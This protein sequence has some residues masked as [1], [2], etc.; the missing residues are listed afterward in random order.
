[1]PHRLESESFSNLTPVAH[2]GQQQRS[3]SRTRNRMVVE[4]TEIRQD[5]DKC[6]NDGDNSR[7]GGYM[8]VEISM[9]VETIL[10]DST[11]SHYGRPIKVHCE[12]KIIDE[13]VQQRELRERYR[14]QR[15]ER[16]RE[17]MN[18]QWIS[19]GSSDRMGYQINENYRNIVENDGKR[20]HIR[21]KSGSLRE[22]LSDYENIINNRNQLSQAN[23]ERAGESGY[24]SE[25]TTY[26]ETISTTRYSD[27][28][29]T[30]EYSLPIRNTL[31]N[32]S[33]SIA[34]HLPADSTITTETTITTTTA[35][36]KVAS[37]SKFTEEN[38]APR[39]SVSPVPS[40]SSPI[41]PTS[42]TSTKLGVVS[43]LTKQFEMNTSKQQTIDESLSRP[44]NGNKWSPKG[45]PKPKE[46]PQLL[47]SVEFMTTPSGGKYKK[48]DYEVIED[49]KLPR[50]ELQDDSTTKYSFE[51]KREESTMDI[52]SS[53]SDTQ[54]ITPSQQKEQI[55]VYEYD[56]QKISRRSGEK[57][58]ALTEYEQK[59]EKD[60]MP[61]RHQ[62]TE[63]TKT[64]VWSSTSKGVWQYDI[65]HFPPATITPPAATASRGLWESAESSR[66][67]WESAESSRG[68]RD[69]AESRHR[70][71]TSYD[72]KPKPITDNV[73]STSST[74]VIKQDQ[75]G[76]MLSSET[77]DTKRQKTSYSTASTLEKTREL[78]EEIAEKEDVRQHSPMWAIIKSTRHDDIQEK[79]PEEKEKLNYDGSSIRTS[80]TSN[81]E[82]TEK[83][84]PETISSGKIAES[85]SSMMDGTTKT[86]QTTTIIDHHKSNERGGSG[87][88]RPSNMEEISISDYRSTISARPVFSRTVGSISSPTYGMTTATGGRILKTV[89]EIGSSS[90]HSSG[91]SPFGQN[92][93]SAIRDTREREKKEMSDLNDR[94]ASYIEKVRFLEAQNRK[95]AADLNLLRGRWGKDSVS[96]RA[97]YEGELQEARKIINDTNSEREDLEKRI[98]KLM[99]DLTECKKRYD[100]ALRAHQA[101]RKCIDELLVKLS[102]LEAEINL[103]R[104]RV[105]SLEEEVSR[106]KRDNLHFVN[107]LNKARADLD[108]ETL[109]RIDFQ[110]QV[111]T[112]LEEI[113]FMRRVHDQ[114]INEL[115]AMAARD[116][117]PE[118]RE[119]FKNELSSAIRDIRAEYDQIC[120]MN[121]TDMESW[122]KLKV[123]EIQTQSTRQ[124]LE[125]GYA[126]EEVKRLRVQ[127]SELR[128]KLADLEGRNSLLEKQMQEL[129]YQLED[130]Q[131]SYEA[132]LND[133]DA[134]IRKMR[135]ECQ[136]L[137]MELQ[138]LLDTKQTL[139]A[140][141]AIYRKML[142][143]EENRAGLRQLVEQVVKTHG[144]TEVGETETIRVLKGE[145]ASRTSFQR[146]AKGNV[147]I[148]DAA[149]D[150][151][152]VLLENTH[153]SKE[154]AIGE[155]RLKRK[156]DGK[157]E[158][159]Y[160]F[161]RDFILKP[162]KSVKI[163]ARGQGIY[164]PPDQLV[165]DAE[166]SFGI[167][168]NVQTILFNKEGEERASHIQRSS[169]TV[170]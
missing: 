128:G 71:V 2:S 20:T 137:M 92:A 93:A 125:Q 42:D 122:Y 144:L 80:R 167:G 62:W 164:N 89:T 24:R 152:Y 168:S 157:R 105:S 145:T 117:T 106:I 37:G 154:E 85:K 56:S 107:E 68:L 75:E 87:A 141:I 17:Y 121:R 51:K 40:L 8:Q 112:L 124:N 19:S 108:Q 53:S 113:D 1:M 25:S 66:G 140:E 129:N 63:E 95:L 160:T 165:F 99:D 142:E 119:Y 98:R 55:T 151:K 4:R 76:R 33:P 3:Q 159:V 14:E 82:T 52:S 64:E 120:N 74:V 153:R 83:K 15:E 166:E 32:S 21:S 30:P 131:R 13:H 41:I 72:E 139:D 59:L 100:D 104:R 29:G 26:E 60:S 94:L 23:N 61:H 127:L 97:M 111:Q 58:I 96:V 44:I 18:D 35:I 135:E 11:P 6:V 50:N 27:S 65:K 147:S 43:S 16:Q 149:S 69:S 48:I 162:G 130:D 136:A 91:M 146:S 7:G 148:Q 47:P 143:G 155:W 134:Q 110:N 46:L 138:M 22:F 78:D 39:A 84:H 102:G 133:R 161:P 116:T 115:Q 70:N 38:I 57:P 54:F 90:L 34:V 79:E 88:I 49:S 77:W 101:D 81:W 118:N 67:L 150:G 158:I 86:F 10:D 45:G 170:N 163:W 132:A 12:P 31:Y 114:E 9:A 169:H 28:A 126:K 156:I 36:K 123:Q 109:N 103:L 5:Y 73:G